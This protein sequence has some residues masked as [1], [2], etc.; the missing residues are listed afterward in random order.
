MLRPNKFVIITLLAFCAGLV[1]GRWS[2]VQTA[3]AQMS[4]PLEAQYA[5]L[6]APSG[7]YGRYGHVAPSTFASIA[8]KPPTVVDLTEKK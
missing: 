7:V 8:V 3:G 1:I 6:P 5:P 2:G 4:A